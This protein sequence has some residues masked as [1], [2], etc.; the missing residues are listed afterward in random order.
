M[1]RCRPRPCFELRKKIQRGR[2]GGVP[3]RTRADPS[4]CG[5]TRTIFRNSMVL[6]ASLIPAKYPMS[7]HRFSWALGACRWN[8][9]L[10][11]A[12][13]LNAELP[14]EGV[15]N[16]PAPN[17]NAY[18][19]MTSTTNMRKCSHNGS[20]RRADDICSRWIGRQKAHTKHRR[21]L[22]LPGVKLR[23]PIQSFKCRSMT[24]LITRTPSW[25]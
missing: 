6:I 9:G 7:Q 23:R 1:S 22:K 15:S 24:A 5:S 21:L 10:L 18:K 3:P 14:Q 12:N 2:Y 8:S 16:G 20:G 11:Y 19:K 25:R 17:E 4:T 13:R